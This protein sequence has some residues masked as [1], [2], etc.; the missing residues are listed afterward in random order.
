M[1]LLFKVL[2]DRQPRLPKDTCKNRFF[3]D[4]S[5]GCILCRH[6]SLYGGCVCM[7]IIYWFR[8]L[9]PS[10]YENILNIFLLR[11]AIELLGAIILGHHCAIFENCLW[12]PWW[13][14]LTLLHIVCQ[15]T[16]WEHSQVCFIYLFWVSSNLLLLLFSLFLLFELIIKTIEIEWMFSDPIYW[17]LICQSG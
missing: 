13:P 17:A 4:G 12:I 6:W 2:Y 16:P 10:Q 7:W 14:F 8:F 15:H 9:T 5:P 1:E 3:P 11:Q